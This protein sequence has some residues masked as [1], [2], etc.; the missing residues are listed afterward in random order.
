[1]GSRQDLPHFTVGDYV[2]VARVSRQGKHR[3]LKSTWT[4]PWRVANADK[5]QMY[6]VQHLVTAEL[7]DVH[8]A[9]MRFYADD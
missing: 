9:R 8:L 3:K 2:L 5:E 1:M 7:R 4:G 6:A